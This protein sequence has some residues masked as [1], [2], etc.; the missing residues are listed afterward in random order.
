MWEQLRARWTSDAR[1]IPDSQLAFGVAYSSL[2]NEAFDD[3][4]NQEWLCLIVQTYWDTFK[5][6]PLP[7]MPEAEKDGKERPLV[8]GLGTLRLNCIEPIFARLFP[9]LPQR[10]YGRFEEWLE[11]RG[12]VESLLESAREWMNVPPAQQ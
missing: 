4:E 5:G 1:A 11:E 6:A 8:M 10:C 7:S 3:R 2:E 9:D 12:V